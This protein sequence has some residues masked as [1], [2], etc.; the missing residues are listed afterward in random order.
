MITVGMNYHVIEGKQQAFEDKFAAVID[1]LQAAEGHGSSTL[2][3]DVSDDAWIRSSNN[4]VW[5]IVPGRHGTSTAS[6]K[7]PF[8][9]CSRPGILI[10][11]VHCKT[12]SRSPHWSVARG[13]V[14]LLSPVDSGACNPNFSTPLGR[15]SFSAAMHY[16]WQLL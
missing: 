14:S 15:V 5:D 9:G 7:S 3:K 6:T 11:L 13:T 16:H 8:Y 10:E 2:W 1:A 4:N 12:C